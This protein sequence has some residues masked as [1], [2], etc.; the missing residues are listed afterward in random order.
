LAYHGGPSETMLPLKGNPAIG[1]I[2]YKT[3]VMLDHRVVRL[4]P[5][6]DQRVARNGRKRHCNA[7]AVQSSE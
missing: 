6:A 2:P 3:T 5:T 1:V 7:G 4:C